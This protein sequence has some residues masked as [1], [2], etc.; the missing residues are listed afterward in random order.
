[1][2][3]LDAPGTGCCGSSLVA[4]ADLLDAANVTFLRDIAPHHPFSHFRFHSSLTASIVIN[5]PYP[6]RVI[7][8]PPRHSCP[9][10]SN[11]IFRLLKRIA[12]PPPGEGVSQLFGTL[13]CR[14]SLSKPRNADKSIS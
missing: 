11:M 3:L 5:I 8:V 4:R 6:G 2:V 9:I 14:G 10:S 1:M 12:S 13:A 7:Y